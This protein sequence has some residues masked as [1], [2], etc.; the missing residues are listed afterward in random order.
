VRCASAESPA[1]DWN[2]AAEKLGTY[3]LKGHPDFKG[4]VFVEVREEP[5][6]KP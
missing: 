6:S 1:T 5:S 4:L 3:L 2:I